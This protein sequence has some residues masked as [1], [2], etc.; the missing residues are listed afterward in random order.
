MTIDRRDTT[1]DGR[2]IVYWSDGSWSYVSEYGQ[3]GTKNGGLGV[4]DPNGI[5]PEYDPVVHFQGDPNAPKPGSDGTAYTLTGDGQRRY[6]APSLYGAPLPEGHNSFFSSGLQW[7]PTTGQYE[8]KSMDPGNILALA[9]AGALTGGALSTLGG[10]GAAPG[11]ADLGA[12]DP[13]ALPGFTSAADIAAGAPSVVGTAAAPVAEGFAAGPGATSVPA[14]A[15]PTG[16][17]ENAAPGLPASTASALPG[18]TAPPSVS[19]LTAT[20][21]TMPG[22]Y[23]DVSAPGAVAGNVSNAVDTGALAAPS[24]TGSSLANFFKSYAP[25]I[26]GGAATL[27]GAAIQANA[28]KQAA[29]DQLQAAREALAFQEAVYRQKQGQVAPYINMGSGAL[30]DLGTGLGVTPGNTAGTVNLPTIPGQPPGNNIVPTNAPGSGT[31]LSPTARATTIN[32][33]TG[34]PWTATMPTAPPTGALTGLAQPNLA[35]SQSQSG[36]RM[37]APN[38]QAYMVPPEMVSQ[39]QANGGM[40]I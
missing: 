2:P 1:A 3:F 39:A 26:L 8:Q 11:V 24:S 33:A 31:S 23:G 37:R 17:I 21:G 34:Q 18:A 19:D 32:P 36:V 25:S 22:G 16:A 27:G 13:A 14:G 29:A 40:V 6:V 30:A 10:A 7:N 5:G 28:Q 38:G 4:S 15:V 12:V 20:Y 9:T 35:K